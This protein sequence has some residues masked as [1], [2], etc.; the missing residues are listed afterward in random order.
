MKRAIKKLG[1]YHRF[2][3]RVN[4]L[5]QFEVKPLTLAD[6]E[7]VTDLVTEILC[8]SEPLEVYMGG[9]PGI[10]KPINEFLV[11]RSIED[12]LGVICVDPDTSEIASALIVYDN[13]KSDIPSHLLGNKHCGVIVDF[14]YEC[15]NDELIQQL[16]QKRLH[17]LDIIT[18]ATNKKYQKMGLSDHLITWATHEHPRIKQADALIAA[19]THPAA[20]KIL[21]K[22][23]W[24]VR[25]KAKVSEYTNSK[26][27]KPFKDFAAVAEQKLGITG[28]DEVNLMAYIRNPGN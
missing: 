19:C 3:S 7:N 10:M 28:Y 11:K 18:A 5:K 6:C 16:S 26:G 24:Q 15:Y 23:G 9:K 20:Y 27:E 14:M 25:K 8:T 4:P 17:C 21:M 12:D 22:N 13:Y 2:T 1:H